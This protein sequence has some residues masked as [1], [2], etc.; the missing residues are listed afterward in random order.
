MNEKH[1]DKK[2]P[3]H[4][5]IEERLNDNEIATFRLLELLSAKEMDNTQ[6]GKGK[7]SEDCFGC[8]YSLH[9]RKR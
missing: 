1:Y 8:V 3:E 6:G 7:S 9:S 4:K 2:D 5:K